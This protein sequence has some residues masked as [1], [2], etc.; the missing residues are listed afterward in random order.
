MK[1]LFDLTWEAAAP[2]GGGHLV[3]A[4][5]IARLETV[6]YD[7]LD[8]ARLRSYWAYWTL[9]MLH[10]TIRSADTSIINLHLGLG[11]T[12]PRLRTTS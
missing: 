4:S 5:G 10:W 11:E 9:Q 7:T 8:P 3:Q 1:L 6:L 2:S 12:G